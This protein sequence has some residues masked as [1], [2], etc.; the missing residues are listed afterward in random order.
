MSPQGL[1][2]APSVLNHQ[3][4]HGWTLEVMPVAADFTYIE[5][6]LRLTS[7][8]GQVQALSSVAGSG[9]LISKFG[10]VVAMEATHSESVPVRVRVQEARNGQ[11]PVL[12]RSWE[13][14]RIID[15]LFYVFPVNFSGKLENI[16]NV[17]A[18]S[19]SSEDM[20]AL[21]DMDRRVSG[22]EL[23]ARV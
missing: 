10:Q 20:D 9:F 7:P 3:N 19:Y 13:I 1:F 22:T 4:A 2:P 6:D 15:D 14:S 18:L 8:D 17:H 16:F 12:D 5:S 11:V 23:V 21:A